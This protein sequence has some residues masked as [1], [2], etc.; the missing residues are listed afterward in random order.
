VHCTTQ[1]SLHG[2]PSFYHSLS[3]DFKRTS[4]SQSKLYICLDKNPI[5]HL[6]NLSMLIFYILIPI[7]ISLCFTIKWILKVLKGLSNSFKVSQLKRHLRLQLEACN[8]KISLFLFI[9]SLHYFVLD[10]VHFSCSA[11][12]VHWPHPYSCKYT[13]Y[14][15]IQKFLMSPQKSSKLVPTKMF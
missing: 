10:S 1:M 5:G 4:W 8:S 2:A 14:M 11:S 3:H 9:A 6:K 13:L 15:S 12:I 7:A